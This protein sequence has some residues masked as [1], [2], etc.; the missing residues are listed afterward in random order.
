MLAAETGINDGNVAFAAADARDKRV[1][2]GGV[3]DAM[4]RGQR[5]LDLRERW[6]W[7]VAE[8]VQSM[9]AE[10]DAIITRRVFSLVIILLRQTSI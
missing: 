1:P 7:Q 2:R 8:D 4:R 3:C 5:S 6:R 9:G 10:D